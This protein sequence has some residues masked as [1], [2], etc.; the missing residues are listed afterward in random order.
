VREGLVDELLVYQA[1]TLLG[2][3]QGLASFGPL[4]T[5]ADAL[6]LRFVSIER[7]GNDLRLIA[8][9]PGREHF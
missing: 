2:L 9:P 6:A 5:L 8:R 3:G 7:L 1:P 4:D